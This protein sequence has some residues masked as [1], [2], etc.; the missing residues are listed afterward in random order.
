MPDRLNSKRF[1][2]VSAIL[3]QDYARQQADISAGKKDVDDIGFSRYA[4]GPRAG[5]KVT[6]AY[7]VG[8]SSGPAGE[9]ATERRVP[10]PT[11]PGTLQSYV[12]DNS[13]VFSAPEVALGG[14][15]PATDPVT[16]SRPAD[17][18]EALWLDASTAMAPRSS[19]SFR[20]ALKEGVR[21]NEYEVG[22]LGPTGEYEGGYVPQRHM[23]QVRGGDSPGAPSVGTMFVRQGKPVSYEE[24]SVHSR[25]A[26]T[27]GLR[28]PR[29][30]GDVEAD[31]KVLRKGAGTIRQFFG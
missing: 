23:L 26:Y 28:Y 13:G 10:M 18:R 22:E 16:S 5:Q 2:E 1:A 25:E 6:D 19:G 29:S 17:P 21:R 24:T 4:T 9:T 8:G 3:N 31:E 20:A 12:D 30:A 15:G 14:W 11:T 7:M 27:G